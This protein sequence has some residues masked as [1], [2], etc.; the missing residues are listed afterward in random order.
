MLPAGKVFGTAW[1]ETP[2]YYTETDASKQAPLQA[3]LRWFYTSR[4]ELPY[5][6]VPACLQLL[7]TVRLTDLADEASAI[8]DSEGKPE[9]GTHSLITK[10]NPLLDSNMALLAK[11]CVA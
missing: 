3:L 7:Q 2:T 10:F 1:E 9:V 11:A 5:E 6:A 4:L 8:M